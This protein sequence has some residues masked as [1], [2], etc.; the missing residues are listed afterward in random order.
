M[1]SEA[2]C[3]RHGGEFIFTTQLKVARIT[4]EDLKRM[5]NDYGDEIMRL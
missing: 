2:S 1:G 4:I 3:R 5:R